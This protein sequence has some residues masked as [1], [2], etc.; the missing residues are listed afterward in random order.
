MTPAVSVVIP[1]YNYGHYVAGALKSALRQ[2]CADLEVI[3]VD[4]ASTDDTAAVVRPY[5]ADARV[6]YHR[7]PH[8][9]VSAA[10]NQGIHLARAPLVAFLDAD[11]LWLPRKLERQ[12]AF[13]RAD[14]EL[15]VVYARRVLMDQDGR[16]V[17]YVQPTLHRGDV[18]R[19][20]FLTNFV[21]Q[22]AAVVRRAVF[23][24][25][26]LYDE[27][28]PPSEDWDLWLRAALRYRFD[29]VDEPLVRYRV[30]HASLTKRS[31]A[32][33]LTRLEVMRRFLD[34]RGGRKLLPAA[35]VRQ[36]W[37]DTYVNLA[38][39]WRTHSPWEALKFNLKA[40]AAC[41][42][43]LPAWKGLATALVPERGRRWLRRALGRPVDWR[44]RP[45]VAN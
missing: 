10:K 7:V 33:L 16:A 42:R 21:C 29:Y 18:V 38:L 30:G 40:T 4:D 44:V 1:T 8:G 24:E 45:S 3:V 5:L 37:A 28:Y 31:G 35:L 36:A 19:P 14:P 11:D 34:E 20:L 43:F 9:G 26:G 41:P 2:T 22:S 6:A 15:G 32:R 39:A 17:P 27:R 25:V 13:F 23:A 12:L